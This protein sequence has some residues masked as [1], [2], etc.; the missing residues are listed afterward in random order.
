MAES[1]HNWD[2]AGSDGRQD[3]AGAECAGMKRI[4]H[5]L[6]GLA[7]AGL[8][9]VAGCQRTTG[10]AA[11]AVPVPYRADIGRLCDVVVQSGADQLPAGE[12]LLAIVQW[13]PDHLETQDSRDFLARIQPLEG[14]AKADALDAEA[15]RV[16]LPGC[17]L[18]AE[19]RADG[20][21]H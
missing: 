1:S 16:G 19:W 12:R 17:A 21:G 4:A 11:A 2:E 18:A 10:T 7:V 3:R 15:R 8:A 9:I 14:E 20:H 5:L 13:L 6:A